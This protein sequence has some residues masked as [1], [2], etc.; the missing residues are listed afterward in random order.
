MPKLEDILNRKKK[1]IF[2]KVAY[3]PWESTF[4]ESKERN[5][6]PPS[7]RKNPEDFPK[8]IDTSEIKKKMSEDILTKT[9]EGK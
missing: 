5:N 1:K 2:K 6:T 4:I 9:E 7:V 3:K 8:E